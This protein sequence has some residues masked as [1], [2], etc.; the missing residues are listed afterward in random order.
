MLS[1][2]FFIDISGYMMLVDSVSN[3]AVQRERRR[4]SYSN[5]ALTQFT[6]MHAEEIVKNAMKGELYDK[7]L[8]RMG[9]EANAQPAPTVEST[10][11]SRS[12]KGK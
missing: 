1:V 5:A 11:T 6:K 4:S 12:R 2:L 8:K 9:K 7:H 10:P 3:L